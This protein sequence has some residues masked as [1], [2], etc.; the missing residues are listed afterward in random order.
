MKLDAEVLAEYSGY[1]EEG[2]I[3]WINIPLSAARA[4]ELGLDPLWTESLTAKAKLGE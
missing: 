4:R 3:E 2:E 1:V